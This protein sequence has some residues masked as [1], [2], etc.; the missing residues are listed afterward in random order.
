[1]PGTVEDVV[2]DVGVH[3]RR[4][5]GGAGAD[6]LQ[7]VQQAPHVVALR[8]ALAVHEA[9]A[10]EL[11][12]RVE[13]PVGG[14]EVD[15]GVVGPAGEQGLQHASRGALADGDAA[16]DADDVR[17]RGSLAAEERGDH[18]ATGDRGG[19]VQ[20]QQPRERQ[21][22]RLHL[23]EV[24]VL[25]QAAQ[26]V[27][28]GGVERQRRRGPQG[29][30]LITTEALVQPGVHEWPRLRPAHA[31]AKVRSGAGQRRRRNRRL[32]RPPPPGSPLRRPFL[33]LLGL[34]LGED[35]R[36][37]RVDDVLGLVEERGDLVPMLVEARRLR[38]GRAG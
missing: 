32:R 1:M 3:R 21:V 6:L 16:G 23:L 36:S 25:V 35:R 19:H 34:D 15:P 37:G 8:E 27:E 14:H 26:L 17:R 24:E 10:L 2:G 5:L 29:P 31:A 7:E 13:E 18:L 38:G 22:D 9:P 30:P 11:V 20:V 12:V 28:V 4:R 33:P